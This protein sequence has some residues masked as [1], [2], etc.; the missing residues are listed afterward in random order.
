MK[1]IALAFGMCMALS[2]CVAP[3][4]PD[5]PSVARAAPVPSPAASSTQ[6]EAAPRPNRAI[7]RP[8][9]DEIIRVAK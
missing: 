2:G 1:A 3:E 4:E 8:A 9:G 6:F 5:R 7:G